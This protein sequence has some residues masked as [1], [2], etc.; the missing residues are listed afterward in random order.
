MTVPTGRSRSNESRYRDFLARQHGLITTRQFASIGL[1]PSATAKRQALGELERVLPHV[2]R[3]TLIAPTFAQRALAAVLWAGS[4]AVASHTTALRLY[5]SDVY[6]T[7]ELHLWVPV[8]RRPRSPLVVVH[9]D[10]VAQQDRR[11]RQRVPVTSPA[12]TL[13]DAA[14][15]LDDETF[16]ALVED[17]LHRGVTTPL[18]IGRCL[19]AVGGKG[20][21]GSGRLAALLADRPSAALDRRLE[22]K[23]W[24]LLRAAGLQPV[25]QLEVRCSGRKYRLD[26]AFPALKVAVE[27]HGFGAHGGRV[28]HVRDNRRLADLVGDGWRV[29]PVTWEAVT[30]DSD[31]VIEQVRSALRQA[32]A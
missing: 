19:T 23:I 13:V 1:S 12:R 22:V 25:R 32:A 14:G 26:F 8:A 20:R 15:V 6:V 28:A 18:A 30:T 29:V 3:S 4:D 11:M 31:R 16:E 7:D 17:F 27:G 9:R 24:R 21:P 10:V 5:S 2:F